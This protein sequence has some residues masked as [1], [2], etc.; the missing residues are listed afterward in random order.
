MNVIINCGAKCHS[1][2]VKIR[3]LIEWPINFQEVFIH[4][5]CKVDMKMYTNQLSLTLSVVINSVINSVWICASILITDSS[6]AGGIIQHHCSS[7]SMDH[8]VQIIGYNMTGNLVR[9]E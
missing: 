7:Q 5:S 2:G 6:H 8:A 4:G 3:S 9:I 1:N